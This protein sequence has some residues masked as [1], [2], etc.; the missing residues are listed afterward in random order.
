MSIYFLDSSAIAKRYVSEQGHTWIISL[1]DP[2]QNHELYISQAALVEVVA[3]ICRRTRE[4]SIT[5]TDRDRL[6]HAFRLDCMNNYNILRITSP[7]CTSAGNLCRSYRLRAYDAVQLACALRLRDKAL[8][9]EME[10]PIFVSADNELLSFA[11]VE[12]LIVENPSNHP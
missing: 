7:I 6:I 10:A 12:E 11:A 2:E 3:A 4:Q 8:A 5:I 1:C 9:K